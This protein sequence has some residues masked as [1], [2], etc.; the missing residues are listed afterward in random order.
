[1]DAVEAEEPQTE[2]PDE[3]EEEGFVE[4]DPIGRF[5]RV[6][7]DRAAVKASLPPKSDPFYVFI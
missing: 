3:E 1:M 4:K 7:R 2:P 5:I 6:R